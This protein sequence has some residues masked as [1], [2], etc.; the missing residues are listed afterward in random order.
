MKN[1]LHNT[2]SDTIFPQ[3]VS[4][5]FTDSLERTYFSAVTFWWRSAPCWRTCPWSCA[6]AWARR[7]KRPSPSARTAGAAAPLRSRRRC[8]WRH[9]AG[10]APCA[11]ALAARRSVRW[12]SSTFHRPSPRRLR[13]PGPGCL[14]GCA[15]GSAAPSTRRRATT[16]PAAAA[17]FQPLGVDGAGD[18]RADDLSRCATWNIRKC[19]KL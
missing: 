7:G 13:P 12:R 16:L 15:S 11:A 5:H 17:G 10:A 3:P 2:S 18:W 6:C 19:P 9:A 14:P 4:A 8:S 1:Y